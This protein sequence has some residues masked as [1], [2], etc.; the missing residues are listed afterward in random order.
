VSLL[1]VD[2]SAVGENGRIGAGQRFTAG[3]GLVGDATWL[4]SKYV[5]AVIQIGA[6]ALTNPPEFA[7][8][9]AGRSLIGWAEFQ[10]AA[11]LQLSIP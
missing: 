7:A 2:A 8:G 6:E 9:G 11:G 5:G 4:F 3:V 10:L 1:V